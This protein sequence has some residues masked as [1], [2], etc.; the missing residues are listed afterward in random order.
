MKIVKRNN[1]DLL[2]PFKIAVSSEN[3]YKIQHILFSKGYEWK[4]S[5]KNISNEY[6]EYIFVDKNKKISLT[7]GSNYFNK[8]GNTLIKEEDILWK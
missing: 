4:H 5:G 8:H 6:V 3:W 2:L 1:I 7:M